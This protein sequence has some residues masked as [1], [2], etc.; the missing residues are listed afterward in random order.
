MDQCLQ[1]QIDFP[2]IYV[3]FMELISTLFLFPPQLSGTYP[4]PQL[5]LACLLGLYLLPNCT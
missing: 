5:L 4:F 3:Q 1:I 2:L